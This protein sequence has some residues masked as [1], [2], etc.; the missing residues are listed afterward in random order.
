[1]PAIPV[2]RQQTVAS[3]QLQAPRGSPGL[4]GGVSDLGQGLGM[5]ADVMARQRDQDAAA[6]VSLKLATAQS[7]WSQHLLQRQMEAPAGADGFTPGLLKDF[8]DYVAKTVP[9]AKTTT[10]RNFLNQR[11]TEFRGELGNKALAFEAGARIADRTEKFEAARN[12]V[13][14]AAE[15]DPG[16]YTKRLAEQ[17][18]ILDSLDIPA[19]EKG[20]LRQDTI[21]LV[22]GRAAIGEARRNPDAALQRITQPEESDSL[23]RSLTPRARDAV[24]QEIESQ[25]RIRMAAEDRAYRDRE[26]GERDMY[27]NSAKAGD[28]LLAEGKLTASWI[29]SNK[30]RMSPTDVRYFYRAMK[31]PPPGGGP[32][33]PMAYAD[34]RDRAGRGQDVRTEAREALSRGDIGPSEFDRIV[35]ETEQQR[36]GWYKRGNDFIATASGVS[37][38]NPDPAGAQRKAAMLDDWQTWAGENPKASD[39]EARDA[40]KRIVSEYAIVDYQQMTLVKR[41]PQFLVGGRNAPDFDATEA[42]TAQAFAEKRITQDEALKQAAMIREWRQAYERQA[43]AAPA[44]GTKK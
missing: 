36:P 4:G 10:A 29:E 31:E 35:G 17:V 6:D 1:M 23:F 43:A 7:E 9:T 44:K 38:L 14:S 34:M 41:A 22:T 24:Y 25:Q 8:D 37:D 27:D 30:A 19:T 33:N 26:R 15:V 39:T 3:G 5:V 20:K 11:L 40:Y 21:D 28:K 18:S 2:I 16:S 42:A 32:R 13:A 12:Q